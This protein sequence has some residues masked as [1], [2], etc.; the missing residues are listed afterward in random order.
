MIQWR[1]SGGM[2][3]R[4][5]FIKAVQTA[6]DIPEPARTNAAAVKE[7]RAGPMT[8]SY[9][10]FLDRESKHNPRGPKWEDLMRRRLANMRPYRDA[11]IAEGFIFIEGFTYLVMV[12]LGSQAVIHWEESKHEKANLPFAAFNLTPAPR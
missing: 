10:D 11:H 7:V 4:E 9:L 5:I 6:R 2:D 3:T 8:Q 1:L 12:D